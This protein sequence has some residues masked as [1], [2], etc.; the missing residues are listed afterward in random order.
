MIGFSMNSSAPTVVTAIM[1]GILLAG[2]VVTIL[3]VTRVMKMSDT[4]AYGPFLA[5]GGMM[6]LF[7]R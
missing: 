3:L 5:A 7:M 4:L 6:A 1:A 2:V